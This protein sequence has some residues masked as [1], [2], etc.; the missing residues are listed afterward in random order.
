MQCLRLLAAALVLALSGSPAHAQ[1][2]SASRVIEANGTTTLVHEVSVPAPPAD[3]WHA[4]STAEGWMSWAVPVAWQD[5]AGPGTLETSYDPTDTPGSPGT[6]LQQFVATIPGRMLA[7]RTTKTPEGFPEA[8]TYFGVTSIFELWE[9][10]GGTR[11][12]LTAVNYPATP[13]GQQ[14]ADFFT[15]GNGST[16]EQLRRS[17]TRP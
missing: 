12:R 10:D 11:V 6:I 9:Q 17:F 8:E 14:L 13:A 16:L 3:V 2:V 7:F 1:S 4:I 15:A 5:T